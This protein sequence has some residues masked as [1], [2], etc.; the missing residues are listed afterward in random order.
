MSRFDCSLC[1]FLL[2]LFMFWKPHKWP[3]LVGRRIL[4]IIHIPYQL[5]IQLLSSASFS[6]DP[7]SCSH[8][9]TSLSPI[10]ISYVFLS[11]ILSPFPCVSHYVCTYDLDGHTMNISMNRNL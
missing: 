6:S 10:S 4:I 3:D 7:F 9:Y 1:L 5:V 2:L 8:I 11:S